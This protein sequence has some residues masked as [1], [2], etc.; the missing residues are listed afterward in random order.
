[1]LK[2]IY[3]VYTAN[4][5][6]HK[7]TVSKHAGYLCKFSRTKRVFV[8]TIMKVIV[9]RTTRKTTCKVWQ[10]FRAPTSIIKAIDLLHR[11]AHFYFTQSMQPY[12]ARGLGNFVLPPKGLTR[13]TSHAIVVGKMMHPLSQNYASSLCYTQPRLGGFFH[14]PEKCDF[15]VNTFYLVP[16][17]CTSNATKC[18]LTGI[19]VTC[20]QDKDCAKFVANGKADLTYAS[21]NS[22]IKNGEQWRSQPDYLVLLC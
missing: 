19:N 6:N 16:K 2:I 12:E 4:C 21:S 5:L 7:H 20:V 15:F 14:C 13:M 18:S 11:T 22:M 1:M 3:Y 9:L 8:S 17:F 10:S